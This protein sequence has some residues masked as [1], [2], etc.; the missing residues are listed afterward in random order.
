MKS[1]N[2]RTS[3][4]VAVALSWAFTNEALAT[5]PEDRYVE[6][7]I[8]EDPS[9]ESS[10]VIFAA[11]LHLHAV[12]VVFS[13]VVWEV[14]SAEF[15]EINTSGVAASWSITSPTVDTPSGF[16][17]VMHVDT[18][19]PAVHEFDTPPLIEGCANHISGT[20]SD[21]D[22]S[23]GSGSLTQAQQ[24]MFDGYVAG[25]SHTFQEVNASEPVVEG[26]DEPVE[27]A[28]SHNGGA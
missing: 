17:S 14:E 5:P 13:N 21:L 20:T 23:L 12:D 3:T 24:A 25:L 18:E 26:D 11:R 7:S 27:V 22:F 6:Y 9:D 15:E 28:G 1:R 8:R 10:D 19:N 16:W 4:L 2:L